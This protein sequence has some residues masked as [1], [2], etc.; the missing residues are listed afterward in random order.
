VVLLLTKFQLEQIRSAEFAQQAAAYRDGRDELARLITGDLAFIYPTSV[1]IQFAAA[2]LA[3]IATAWLGRRLLA[4]ALPFFVMVASIAPSYWGDGASAPQPLGQDDWGYWSS[5][6]LS[7][8]ML[9]ERWGGTHPYQHLTVW[10]LVLGS[11]FQVGLWCLPLIAAPATRI[12]ALPWKVVIQ[13][14]LLP[15]SVLALAVLAVVSPPTSEAIYRAPLVAF[16]IGLFATALA[17]TA[18]PF[19]VRVAAAI[20]VPAVIAP[21]ALSSA[22]DNDQQGWALAVAT[23]VSAGLALTLT[24]AQAWMRKHLTSRRTAEEPL[25]AIS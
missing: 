11:L 1:V 18:R 7:P 9:L 24:T 2:G 20:L 3:I 12:A 6:A 8:Q 5:L 25:P 17:T 13:R 16:G 15:A 14:G 22:L 4:L 23:A 10:P 19:A 21:I